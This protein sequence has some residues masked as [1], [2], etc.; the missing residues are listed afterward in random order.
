[1]YLYGKKPVLSIQKVSSISTKNISSQALPKTKNFEQS[2]L[3]V[4]D[5]HQVITNKFEQTDSSFARVMQQRSKAFEQSIKDQN[6]S[7]QGSKI[8]SQTAGFL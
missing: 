7:T 1:L 2:L 3:Q 8:N 4:Y 6:V 5:Q